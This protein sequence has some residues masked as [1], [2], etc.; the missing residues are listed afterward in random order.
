M[1]NEE[2][3]KMLGDHKLWLLGQEGKRIDI[4]NVDLRNV[5]LRKADLRNANLEGADLSDAALADADL[6]CANLRGATLSDTNLCGANLSGTNLSGANLSSA[7]IGKV[8][9]SENTS[10]FALQCPEE[11]S[12]IGWKQCKNRVIVKLLIPEDAQRSSGT[13]R[14]CR[15]SKAVVLEVFGANKGFSNYDSGFVYEL[16]KTMIPD[17]FDENRWEECGKGIHFFITKGEA[18]AY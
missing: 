7:K 8:K 15:A 2:I 18:E 5:D 6:R 16:G 14:K 10:F 12:F 4:I 3:A 17:G 1:T 11:G 13:S 9:C